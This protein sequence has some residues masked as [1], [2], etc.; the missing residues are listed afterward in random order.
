MRS[1]YLLSA[2]VIAAVLASVSGAVAVGSATIMAP[3]VIIS[4]NTGS[5][6]RI[7]LTITSGNGTVSFTNSES[8]ANDTYD[9]AYT[10]ARYGSF[11]SGRN[12]SR[13]N[14]AYSIYDQGNNV[15]GPSAGAAMTLL[16]IS[17]FGN[18]PLRSDFTITGTISPDGTIGQ[19]G[20]A[21]DKVSA[22]AA[23]RL[24]LVLVPQASPGSIEQGVYYIAQIEYGIPIVEVANISQAAAYA[25][26]TASGTADEVSVNFSNDYMVAALPQ[27]SPNCSNGCNEAPFSAFTN[28]TISM[29]KSQIRNLSF[30]R[31]RLGRKPAHGRDGPGL[32]AS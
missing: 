28:Y 3:A 13:Y 14:F 27:A 18:R 16:A 12:F 24:D 29:T 32:C 26:G 5:L 22:A 21:L 6:T 17:A 20:G 31:L 10:A 8:V 7:T 15:S 1:S 19:I 11:Y 9:S 25:F 4:N 23:S 30:V 2:F